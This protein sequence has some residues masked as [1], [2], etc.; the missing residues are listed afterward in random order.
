LGAGSWELGV[1]SWELAGVG[2]MRAFLRRPSGKTVERQSTFY[3]RDAGP[4]PTRPT[5]ARVYRS[6]KRQT[7]NA[8][9]QTPNAKRQTP[10][11]KSQ[12]PNAKR[13]TP[14]AKS[15]KPKAKRQTPKAKSQKPKAKSQKPKAK[16]RYHGSDG[17]ERHSVRPDLAS[18]GISNA[19]CFFRSMNTQRVLDLHNSV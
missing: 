11:A 13:Q 8:K 5:L 1:G 15:Q 16:S 6:C 4:A 12:T 14:N 9:R 10:N 18:S 3:A 17:G 7:P 19:R 2:R